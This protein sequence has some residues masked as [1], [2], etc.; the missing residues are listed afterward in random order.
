VPEYLNQFLADKATVLVQENFVGVEAEWWWE[1]RLGGGIAVCQVLDPAVMAREISSKT[2]REE[3][4]VQRVVEEELDLEDPEPIVLTFELPGDTEAS[5]AAK[6][7]AERSATRRGLAAN[8]Y[9]RIEEAIL[10]SGGYA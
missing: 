6:T 5:E 7:L 8:L 1:R 4:E 9:R 10:G 3:N 2:G